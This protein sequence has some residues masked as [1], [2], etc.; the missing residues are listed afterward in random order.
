M[1]DWEHGIALQAVP[2]IQAS[3]PAEGM[4][5]VISRVMAGTWVIISSYSGDGHLKLHFVQRSQD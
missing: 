2:Y 3:S 1:F 4:S 5:H